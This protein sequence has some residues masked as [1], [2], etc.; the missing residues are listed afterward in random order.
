MSIV[1]FADELSEMVERAAGELRAFDGD[2]RRTSSHSNSWTAK[3]ILGHLIDSAAN[4]HHRFVRAQ[5]TEELK[6]PPYDPRSWVRRHDYDAMAWTEIV[7]LWRLYNKLLSHVVARID[8]RNLD[9]PCWVDWPGRPD[10]IPLGSVM[11]E[12][13]SHLRHHL[14]Q[15]LPR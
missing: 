8:S 4:N 14:D 11:K 13:L 6:F 15:L 5:D 7:E 10:P 12:Y 1:K 3:Q 2:E 9:T